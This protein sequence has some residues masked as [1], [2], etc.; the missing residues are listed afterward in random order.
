M[1]GIYLLIIVRSTQPLICWIIDA[2]HLTC[3]ITVILPG[4]TVTHWKHTGPYL[5]S[6]KDTPGAPSIDAIPIQAM[7][8]A[9]FQYFIWQTENAYI[10]ALTIN[11]SAHFGTMGYIRRQIAPNAACITVNLFFDRLAVVQAFLSYAS[12]QN[13]AASA[14][15]LPPLTRRELFDRLNVMDM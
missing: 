10:K 6:A 15:Y 8:Y 14:Q 2:F 4:T 12:S 13:E 5:F 3:V 11:A 1:I 7:L 9:I